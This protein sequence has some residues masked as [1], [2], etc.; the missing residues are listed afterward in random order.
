[1]AIHNEVTE[2]GIRKET[3]SAFVVSA[4]WNPNPTRR[5]TKIFFIMLTSNLHLRPNGLGIHLHQWQI[6]MGCPTGNNL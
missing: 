3:L 6:A 2:P 5:S 1:M 4:L